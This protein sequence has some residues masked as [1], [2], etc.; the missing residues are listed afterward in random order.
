ML[1]L[2][3]SDPA[4]IVGPRVVLVALAPEHAPALRAIRATPEVSARWP[5]AEGFPLDDEPDAV[6]FVVFVGDDP[7][8]RGLVQFGEEL[9]ADYRHASIDIFLDPA[10]HGHGYGREV[11]STIAGHLIDERGHHRITID[12]AADNLAAI[13]CYS[14]VGFRRVGI[15]RQYER[16]PDGT[17]HD[18][19]LM[20]LLADELIRVPPR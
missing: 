9:T 7:Q 5:D 4:R 6:R 18:G 15:M 13:A 12:P 10:V 8:P 16:G 19:L 17:F 20:D 2:M 11:V 14:A 1:G 3:A